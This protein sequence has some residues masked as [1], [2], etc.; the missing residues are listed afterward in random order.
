MAA[1]G[2]RPAAG[3]PPRMPAQTGGDEQLLGFRPLLSLQIGPKT[4]TPA[5][6]ETRL[7]SYTLTRG[8]LGGDRAVSGS[9]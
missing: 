2:D 6:P 5:I 8:R 4:K 1:D 9:Y 3:T 7:S